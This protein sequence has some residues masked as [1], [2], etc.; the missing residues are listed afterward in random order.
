MNATMAEI[1][2]QMKTNLK[3]NLA[4][5]Q[6]LFDAIIQAC[7]KKGFKLNAEEVKRIVKLCLSLKPYERTRAINKLIDD[8]LEKVSGVMITDELYDKLMSEVMAMPPKKRK[9]FKSTLTD[10]YGAKT[11]LI[12]DGELKNYCTIV[13]KFVPV[14]SKSKVFLKHTKIQPTTKLGYDIAQGRDMDE[15]MEEANAENHTGNHAGRIN[16]HVKIPAPSSW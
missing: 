2:E 8:E 3:D 13:H 7:Q 4:E 5:L 12:Y 9:N 16:H 15:V 11:K 1:S 6:P 10:K 14:M